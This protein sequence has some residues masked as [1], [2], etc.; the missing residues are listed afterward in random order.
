MREIGTY[1][2][3]ETL[4][5]VHRR[6]SDAAMLAPESRLDEETLEPAAHEKRDRIGDV[7]S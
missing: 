2:R 3:G 5:I 7:T 4:H 6:A 1:E